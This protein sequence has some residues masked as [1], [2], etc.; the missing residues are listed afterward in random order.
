MTLQ[1]VIGV[2]GIVVFAIVFIAGLQ[3]VR[4]LEEEK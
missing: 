4:G 1:A 3:L 2:V